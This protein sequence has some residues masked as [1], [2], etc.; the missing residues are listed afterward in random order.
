MTRCGE[1]RRVPARVLAPRRPGAVLLE[2]IV[3]L[4]ILAAAGTAMVTLAAESA[5]AMDRAHVAERALA[6]ADAFFH[7]VALWPREDLD[8]HLGMH[9]QG[10]W[11]LR[12]ER[13]MPTLYE[14]TLLDSAGSRVLLRTTLYRPEAPD[15]TP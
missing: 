4:V 7:A 1:A 9:P 12:I 14:A 8:R 13:P 10:P 3:A 6:R 5:R 11:L 2:A 15:A